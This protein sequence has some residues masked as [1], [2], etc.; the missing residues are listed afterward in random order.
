MA[1]PHDDRIAEELL[2]YIARQPG[3][4]IHGIQSYA[5]LADAFG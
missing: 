3:G 4:R 5:P 1:F 2:K